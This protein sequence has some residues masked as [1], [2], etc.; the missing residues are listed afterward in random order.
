[1]GNPTGGES[2]GTVL[3]TRS[4][5]TGSN[6]P[7]LVPEPLPQRLLWAEPLRRRRADDFGA[8]RESLQTNRSWCG[9]SSSSSSDRVW[10][11]FAKAATAAPV[12]DSR[13]LA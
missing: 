7:L 2:S 13:H 8:N 11:L 12:S 5:L 9:R 1:M 10:S 4:A 6:R 3:A